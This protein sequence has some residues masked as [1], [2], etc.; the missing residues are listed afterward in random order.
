VDTSPGP[1]SS[2]AGQQGREPGER[3]TTVVAPGVIAAIARRAASEVDGVETVG[4]TGLSGALAA[5]RSSSSGGASAH[6]ASRRA[7]ID[8]DIAVQ[9]PR[10]VASVTAAVRDHVRSRV[11]SLTGHTVTDV[12]IVVVDLPA[13]RAAPRPRVR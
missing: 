5:L 11:Q 4:P 9:W 3:G 1:P 13:P 7:V 6:V 10:S 8:L 12:D 2:A